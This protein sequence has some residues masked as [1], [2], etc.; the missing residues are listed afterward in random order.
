MEQIMLLC[1]LIT[2]GIIAA[3]ALVVWAVFLWRRVVPANSLLVLIT[4]LAILSFIAWAVV[5]WIENGVG[6]MMA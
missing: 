5:K 4:G 2:L 6:G 1:L 3:I